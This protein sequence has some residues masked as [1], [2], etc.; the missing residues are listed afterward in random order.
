MGGE[1]DKDIQEN[2]VKKE[3]DP[4]NVPA[5]MIFITLLTVFYIGATILV[6]KGYSTFYGTLMLIPLLV[7]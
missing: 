3:N 6:L 2:F 4:K 1:C 5:S 7:G